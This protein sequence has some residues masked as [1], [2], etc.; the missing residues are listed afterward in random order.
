[1][2]SKKQ[3]KQTRKTETESDTE[4]ILMAAKWEG[5]VVEWVER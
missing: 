1:M 3:I 4:R 5:D 2:E